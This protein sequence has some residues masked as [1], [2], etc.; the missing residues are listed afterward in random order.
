MAME[1][2]KLPPLPVLRNLFSADPETGKLYW[3]KAN[4]HRKKSLEAGG[5]ATNGRR[6]VHIQGVTYA[7]SRIL[8]ALYTGRDPG[9]NYIDHINGDPSDNRACN[10]RAVTPSENSMNKRP[11]GA[12]GYRGVYYAKPLVDGEVRYKVQIC[13]AVGRDENGKHLRKTYDFGYFA[14]LADAIRKAEEA[15]EEWG[16]LQFV[17][18]ERR[19]PLKKAPKKVA[20]PIAAQVEVSL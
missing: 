18:E 10:L 20:A 19:Y 7:V 4:H 9:A 13:R 11:Y 14:N 2:R 8:Y 1:I 15:H 6:N 5:V 3:R 16:S 17:P 12:T